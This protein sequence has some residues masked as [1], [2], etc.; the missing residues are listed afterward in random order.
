MWLARIN[1]GLTAGSMLV[2]IASLLFHIRGG[3]THEAADIILFSAV[4]GYVL[5]TP[6]LGVASLVLKGERRVWSTVSAVL[7]GLWA[8]VLIAGTFLHL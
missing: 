1:L 5:L 2:L 3:A 4:W 8:C 6:V 7:L